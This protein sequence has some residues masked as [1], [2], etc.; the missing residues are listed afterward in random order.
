MKTTACMRNTNTVSETAGAVD[1]VN[2]GAKMKACVSPDRNCLYKLAIACL[3][4]VDTY[5]PLSVG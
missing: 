4:E 5:F 2:M 1:V 3:F